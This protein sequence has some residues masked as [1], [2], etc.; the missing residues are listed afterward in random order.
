MPKKQV[1]MRLHENANHA[2]KIREDKIR[3]D[4]ITIIDNTVFS[5]ENVNT[6][7]NGLK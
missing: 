2:D 3:K 5:N 4:K 6:R 7:S 1:A